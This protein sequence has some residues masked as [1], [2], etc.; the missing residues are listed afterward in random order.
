MQEVH[1]IVR[2]STNTMISSI[3]SDSIDDVETWTLDL[4]TSFYVT[5]RKEWFSLYQYDEFDFV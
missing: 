4:A 1:V 5:R 2:E 3:D